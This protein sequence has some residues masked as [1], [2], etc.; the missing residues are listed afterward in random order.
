VL[1]VHS[2]S[3]R[4]YAPDEVDFLVSV[5]NVVSSAIQRHHGDETLRHRA[6]H[7][8]L[9]GLPN[10]T[11]ALDRLRHALSLHR[12]EHGYVGVLLL[13]VDGFKVV[14]DSL[15][16]NAGD[17]V[18]K[19]LAPRLRAAAR[20]AD[21]VARL[22]GD[23]FIVVCERL[24][25]PRDAIEI[26]E[27]LQRA[28]ARPMQLETGEHV[29]SA[30]I[31][32][33]LTEVPGRGADEL[34]RDADAAMYRAKEKGRGRYELFDAALR[35]R[36]VER[37]RVEHDLRGAL[38]RDELRVWYQP[39]VSVKADGPLAV[40]ALVRWQDPRRGLITPDAFVN[41][42][43]ETGLITRVGDAVL[44]QAVRDVARWQH[45]FATPLQVCVNASGRQLAYAGFASDVSDVVRR[46]G[47][48]PGTL[49]LEITESVLVGGAASPIPVLTS[50]REHGLR[51]MLDDFGTGY[52]SL[53][54]LK[55]FPVDA[56][57]IDQSFIR[58]IA[59]PDDAAIVEAIIKM[60]HTVGLTTVAEG[61][62]TTDQL[63]RLR[64]LGC[65]R[66][67]G[68]LFAAPMPAPDLE[69]FL[70]ERLPGRHALAR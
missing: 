13:D 47:L 21:T 17:E 7:D 43:E 16:H 63:Q 57:K 6:L 28:V 11:L 60:A 32:I 23:E 64:S 67:Q 50:L 5:A 39:I 70:R 36:V 42:A 27:R 41:I 20:D 51:L 56:L 19:T 65:R 31:G 18:L 15:G 54:Y 45:Q 38:E 52:S 10:R 14:N 30:S 24:H 29:L 22:G 2:R 44:R 46:G 61:V 33:A 49:A 62:E 40:E 8:A 3:V 59:D 66:A 12:R 58:D 37:L 26:A 1:A 4:D 53:S 35:A 9:T 48:A 25:G 55:R 69:E 34:V 68:F